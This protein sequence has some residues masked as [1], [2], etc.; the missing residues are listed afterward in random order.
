MA[1]LRHRELPRSGA[2][3]RAQNSTSYM[4]T[5]EVSPSPAVGVD[6]PR[7]RAGTRPPGG[8]S[9]SGSHCGWVCD[10]R[11][12]RLRNGYIGPARHGG[13]TWPGGS[14]LPHEEERP[15]RPGAAGGHAGPGEGRE[16]PIGRSRGDSCTRS[17]SCPGFTFCGDASRDHAPSQS[18]WVR[19]PRGRSA[20]GDGGAGVRGFARPPRTWRTTAGST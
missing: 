13:A 11:V 20:T 1:L 9:W 6:T 15:R 18:R 3:R 19:T 10:R 16:A 8:A 12:K 7:Q 17:T 4:S 5:V 14:Y 2:V